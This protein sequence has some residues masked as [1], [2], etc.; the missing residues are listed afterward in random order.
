MVNCDE[1]GWIIWLRRTNTGAFVNGSFNGSLAE[2]EKGIY[3]NSYNF[4][5]GLKYLNSYT[6][7]SSPVELRVE[8]VSNEIK[9]INR[10]SN[11]SVGTEDLYKFKYDS[12]ISSETTNPLEHTNG[13]SFTTYDEDND[14][15]L[16]YLGYYN[17]ALIHGTGWWYN[18]CAQTL[19]TGIFGASG[20]HALNWEGLDPIDSIQFKMK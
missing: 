2:F 8:I 9:Y 12:L 4:F 20:H 14:N 15:S 5:T 18:N 16:G 17:C 1:E 6:S 7:T 11:F 10:Y 13:S 19:P 3:H